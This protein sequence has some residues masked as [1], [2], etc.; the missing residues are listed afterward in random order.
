MTNLKKIKHPLFKKREKESKFR[1]PMPQKSMSHIGL[2]E[3]NSLRTDIP[4]NSLADRQPSISQE[5]VNYI[6]KKKRKNAEDMSKLEFQKLGK[7]LPHMVDQQKLAKNIS[8]WSFNQKKT[9][10]DKKSN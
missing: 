7:P 4:S 2:P 5:N 10:A 8:D 1:K 3:R 6:K 9:L